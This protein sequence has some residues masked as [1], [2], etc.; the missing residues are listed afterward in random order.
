MRPFTK[1]MYV[2]KLCLRVVGGKCI[3][4][5]AHASYKYYVLV[6]SLRVFSWLKN[7]YSFVTFEY[8]SFKK[9]ILSARLTRYKFF[10]Y[11]YLSKAFFVLQRQSMLVL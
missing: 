3:T 10:F 2:G 7:R 1:R 9:Q 8:A 4:E 6:F 11:V 5:H